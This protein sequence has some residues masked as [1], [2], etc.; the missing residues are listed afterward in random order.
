MTKTVKNSIALL[1]L[2]LL[3]SQF[4]VAQSWL[5]LRE[6]GANYYDIKA[7][8]ER[9][10]RGKLKEMNKELRREVSEGHADA[11]SEQAMEG[12]V[13][14]M[15]WSNRVAPRV[16]ESNGDLGAIGA[17][18]ARA[19]ME[20]SRQLSTNRAGATW[21]LIGPKSTPANGGNGRVNA[22]RAHPT[23]PTTLFACTPA[24][25]L[26][27]TTNSGTSWAPIADGIAL[28]GATDVAFDPTNPNIMYLATGDGEA[29]DAYSTGIYKSIDGG[30]TW[31]TTGLTFIAG[32]KKLFSKII[33]NPT[34]GA[35]VVGGSGGIYRSINGGTNWTQVSTLGVRDLEAK[36]AN[37]SVLYAGGYGSNI[38]LRSL[39][40]GVTWATAGTGLPVSGVQRVAVAVTALDSNYVYAF[41]ANNT[42][43]GFK[44]LYLSTNGGTTFTLQSS[45]P[46][47]LG[48]NASGND[49][50]GQGW[51]DLS[52]AVD[53]SVKTTIYVGGVNVWKSTNSGA[54]W[55]C[56]AHWSGSGAP[57]IH[58]DN[59]DFTFVGSTLWVGNDGGVFSSANGGS[60]WSDKSSTLANAQLY[61]MGQSATNATK[62]LS[63]HQDNGTNLTT[64]GTTWSQNLGGDGMLCFVDRTNDNQMFASIYNGALYRSTNGGLSFGNIKNIA[65]GGWVTPWL[66]DP[67]TAATIYAGGTNV[68]KSVDNGSTWTVISAFSGVGTLV[69]LDVAAT[70]AQCILAASGTK[71]MKTI[72][73]GT[74]WTDITA[75][76][77]AGT[78]ILNVRFDPTN[79]SKIFVGLASYTGNSAFCSTDGGTTWVNISV[80]LPLVP[81]NCF[82]TQ[83]NGDTYCGT[84]IGVYFRGATATTWAAFSAGM[85]GVPV[86]ELR[87]FAP[88]GKLRAAT[89]GR[90]IWESPL[91]SFNNA[92][93]VSITS[94]ANN[95]IFNIGSSVT[96]NAT[97]ADTDGTITKVEFFNGAT[98]LGTSLTAPYTYTWVSPAAG[99]YALTAK[100]TDNGGS[101]KTSA[102]VNISIAIQLDAGISAI[103]TPNGAVGTAT[104]VPSV[105]LKNFGATTLTATPISY[106]VDNNA[107]AIFNWTG[108]LASGATATVALPSVTG[109]ALGA[110]TFTAQTGTVNGSADGNTANNALTSNFTYAVN[111]CT[112]DNETANNSS[113][114]AV[115][116]TANT[117]KTSQ[118][119]KRNDVDYYKFTT[120]ATAPKVKVTLSNL[121]ADYD[122]DLY[123]ATTAG[124]IST[125]I[126]T[127]ANGNTTTESITYNTQTTAKTYYLRV[128]GYGGAFSATTCYNLLV[129][130]S[131]VNFVKVNPITAPLDKPIN[132]VVLLE[133]LSLFPNPTKDEVNVRFIATQAGVYDVAL[134]NSTGKAILT[135]K[136]SFNEGENGAS[137]DVLSMPRG[138]Y[139]VKVS[140]GDE[141]FSQKVILE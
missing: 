103:T 118:I 43:Y 30:T 110:H 89:Y 66:Q 76:L 53:P 78:A 44:G 29:G 37:P 45:T 116:L 32:Q 24:G 133:Q 74:A 25:G 13:Q 75:G 105:T 42:D 31:A 137:F 22:V 60:T 114:T 4:V 39:D 12:M 130:T 1:F 117:A 85:P 33:I 128:Y 17:G 52:I 9:Q 73:G 3:T 101:V 15:R 123:S 48:W 65:G 112:D 122:L 135:Q 71:L 70:N 62:I 86:T 119:G 109:Y 121:P 91:N 104:V 100:A 127:S 79:A 14:F 108:S 94:P 83:S 68:N 57:Y 58:A 132:D 72:N 7:A 51:Y 34:T 95:A 107:F 136:V 10:Y 19:M 63:G 46:N 47:V 138:L 92:P 21:T 20:Q 98:L 99:S 131:N 82:V 90:G 5:E 134:Y 67:V 77:P 111:T 141:L 102:V 28:L 64:N 139:I 59:H 129:Q 120:T 18:T 36:P 16:S 26:W 69:S 55:S 61:G 40:G 126:A 80:G 88:T 2:F 27:K 6:Q 115:I 81:A 41:L 50:G 35:I 49:A 124:A 84:D 23:T 56:I 125:K 54:A 11:K 87:I 97:A 93:S 38:F 8:F 106:K 96:I 113:T 140:N